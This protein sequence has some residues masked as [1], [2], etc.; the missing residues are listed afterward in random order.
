MRFH[1]IHSSNVQLDETRT[2]AKRTGATFCDSFLFSESPLKLNSYISI[3]FQSPSVEWKGQAF[4]GLTTQNPSVFVEN[5]YSKYLINLLTTDDVWLRSILEPWRNAHLIIHLTYDGNLE[6][7]SEHESARKYVLFQNL[8]VNVPLWFVVELYGS[9]S[10]IELPIFN[11]TNS[12]EVV[13][14]CTDA[15]V[16]FRCGQK[17]IVPYSRSR[18]VIIGPPDS[19][20][21]RLKSILTLKPNP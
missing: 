12:L 7:T 19:G 10:E 8:P 9:T 17:G 13:S 5:A 16:V 3:R 15:N 18:I 14:L 2:L 11:T 6:V 4:I 21:N 20:K 1:E